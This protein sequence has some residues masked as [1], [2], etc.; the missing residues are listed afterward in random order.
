[1]LG[2]SS[3]KLWCCGVFLHL[4]FYVK[5]QGRSD[6]M[7][8]PNKH[9]QTETRIV[10]AFS[11][12]GT[13][14]GSVTTA[15]HKMNLLGMLAFL[16]KYIISQSMFLSLVYH[17]PQIHARGQGTQIPRP[18]SN[19]FTCRFHSKLSKASLALNVSKVWHS[20]WSRA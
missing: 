10:F 3:L 16:S 12:C 14:Q 15:R 9:T 2:S 17:R 20:V 18:G 5:S 6:K 11:T 19:L 4:H 8:K 1:M 13:M 7:P